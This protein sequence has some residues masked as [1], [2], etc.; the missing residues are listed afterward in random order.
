MQ[1]AKTVGNRSSNADPIASRQSRK[2]PAPRGPLGMDGAGDDIPWGQFQ[3]R[4]DA[5]EKPLTL[6]VDEGRPFAPQGFGCQRRRILAE[7]Q[8]GR[9]E[10][11]KL[12][13][14]DDRAGA[15][16]HGKAVAVR[17]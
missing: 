3:I 4:M 1:A 5:I 15:R 14:G 2:R 11:D 12:G 7:V 10:L 17:F 8:S 13:I 16:S 9:V 6:G